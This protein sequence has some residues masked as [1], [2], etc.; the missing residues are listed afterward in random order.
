VTDC[1]HL[2][3]HIYNYDR[4]MIVHMI[5]F[6]TRLVTYARLHI[7][8]L[9]VSYYH[10][11]SFISFIVL[12]LILIFLLS[13]ILVYHVVIAYLVF[14]HKHLSL[15]TH[16]Y[17]VASDDAEFARPDTR[18]FMFVTP[19]SRRYGD[20]MTTYIRRADTLTYIR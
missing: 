18:C 14:M 15:Y 11:I 8:T 13:F 17:Y 5:G 3:V 10:D 9:V 1:N 7:L 12:F 19:R 20:V 4:H 2:T 6:Y 16:T